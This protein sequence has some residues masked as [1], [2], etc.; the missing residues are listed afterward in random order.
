MK[1][2]YITNGINGSGGLERVLSIKASYLADYYD[3]DVTILTLNDAHLNP[4]Y[5]FSE[6]IKMIS[7]KVSGNPVQ[8]INSYFK[9]IKGVVNQFK[10]DIISVCDDGLKAYFIPKILSKEI[11]IVYERHVSKIVEMRD[12]YS[13]V[14]RTII[15]MKWNVME[16][17]GN[18]FKKYIVLTEG[19]KEEWKNLKNMCTIA[20]PLSFYPAENSELLNKKVICVGKQSYQ[21][22]QDLLLE[23]WV[24]VQKIHPDWKLE[25]YG[26]FDN[27]LKLEQRAKEL[28]VERSVAFYKPEKNI[29][30]K[31]LESSIYV[32][33]SRFEGFG[34]VLIEAMACG[35]PCVS[36]NCHHGPADII[37]DGIDGYIVDN[38]DVGQLAQKLISLMDNQ[39]LRQQMGRMAKEN[40]KRY[41]PEII[42]KEWDELFKALVK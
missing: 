3:Y 39:S 33:S 21:K 27:S 36:F 1:L 41:L 32:M 34:M 13:F 9:G 12:N 16:L 22:G 37:Q 35:L 6:N 2:L 20:N 14:K 24:K 5:Q 31:Y 10:P 7:I 19:N 29:Q 4:F 18:S 17:L 42:T 8:Y 26:K 28:E 25:L 15:R 11:P 30:S 40:V 38:G 23:A